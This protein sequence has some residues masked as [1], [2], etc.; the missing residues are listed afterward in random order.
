MKN[1]KTIMLSALF[2]VISIATYAGKTS[3]I[4][5]K[6]SG[7]CESCKTRIEKAL[8]EVTGVS[9]AYFNEANGATTVKYDATKTNPDVL[10]TAISK[11]GY[12]ADNIPAVKTAYDALPKCCQKAGGEC[13]H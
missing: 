3:K 13:K 7:V 8:T 12:D 6:T 4:V 2:L 9:S 11:Q 10:R 1:V 5:I